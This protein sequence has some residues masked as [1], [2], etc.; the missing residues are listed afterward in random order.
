MQVDDI[1]KLIKEFSNSDV[2]EFILE[3]NTFKLQLFRDSQNPIVIKANDGKNQIIEKQEEN[4][5]KDI[6][7]EK[8]YNIIKSP[9]VGTF[10][11]SAEEGKLPFVKIGDI[12]T[13]GQIVGIIE[14]MKLMNEIESEYSGKVVEI[15]VKDEQ[16]V[17]YGQPL[18]AIE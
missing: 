9:I 12:I 14:A 13:K 15:F 10:Y 11:A 17:E 1:I 4:K 8:N 18:F 7:E 2:S 3:D 6:E 5:K 16:V